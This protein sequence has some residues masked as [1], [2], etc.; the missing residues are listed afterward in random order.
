METVACCQEG[1]R[2]LTDLAGG[3]M[4]SDAEQCH[5]SNRGHLSGH[6]CLLILALIHSLSLG[7]LVAEAGESLSLQSSLELPFP[8][9]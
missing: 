6:P 7:A 3:F 2:G 8:P 9:P 1:I 5:S 4:G